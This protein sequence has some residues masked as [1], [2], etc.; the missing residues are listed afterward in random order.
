MENSLRTFKVPEP[1]PII[2]RK[3]KSDPIEGNVFRF[4]GFGKHR[5]VHNNS[6]LNTA[7]MY[8]T[9]DAETDGQFDS[10]IDADGFDNI[11]FKD[12]KN[13]CKHRSIENYQCKDCQFHI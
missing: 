9:S 10:D 12:K 8:E 6:H 2:D 5:M 11:F 7:S 4:V 13:K 1:E 3:I